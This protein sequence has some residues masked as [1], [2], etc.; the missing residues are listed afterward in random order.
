MATGGSVRDVTRLPEPLKAPQQRWHK[1]PTRSKSESSP[2]RLYQASHF[3]KTPKDRKTKSVHVTPSR[4][5]SGTP[6]PTMTPKTTTPKV[7]TTPTSSTTHCRYA[8]PHS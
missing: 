6:H 5:N 8:Y 7:G 2:L 3:N 1:L 4:A